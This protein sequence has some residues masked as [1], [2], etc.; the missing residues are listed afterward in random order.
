MSDRAIIAT[1]LVGTILAAICCAAPL[2]ATVLPLA[3]F[4][5]WIAHAGLVVM[6]LM[7]VASL[8]LI[9]WR[10]HRRPTKATGCTTKTH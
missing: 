7:V 10:Q 2:L 3:I 5:A 9:A 6:L 1:G 4:G 8:I